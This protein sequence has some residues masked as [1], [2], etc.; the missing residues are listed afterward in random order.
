MYTIQSTI[1]HFGNRIVSHYGQFTDPDAA[2]Q[3]TLNVIHRAKTGNHY[4]VVPITGDIKPKPLHPS[5]IN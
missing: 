1:N 5:Y 2:H 3:A 4:T